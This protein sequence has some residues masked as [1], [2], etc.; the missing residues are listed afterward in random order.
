[1]LARSRRRIAPQVSIVTGGASGIGRALAA[2]LAARGS[3]VVIADIDGAAARQAA[4]ELPSGSWQATDVSD[5]ASLAQVVDRTVAEHGRLDLIANNAGLAMGGE[6]EELTDRHWE[7]AVQVNLRGVIHGVR[8]AYP[9]MRRQGSGIILNTAS[10]AGLTPV[11]AMLPYTTV[12]HAV[13]GMSLGLRAEGGPLGIRVS[14]LCP[15]FVDTPLLDTVVD[16]PA[17]LGDTPRASIERLQRRLLTPAETAARAMRGLDR[18]QAIIAV[19]GLAHVMWRATRIS[20][21]G[22]ARVAGRARRAVQARIE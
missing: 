6:V 9:V 18:D 11:P 10:L 20:P 1:M 16:P 8:A 13:V 14:A 17:S 15:G 3:H 2:Q 12:K 4:D 7:A 19:G 22:M 5:A 21:G